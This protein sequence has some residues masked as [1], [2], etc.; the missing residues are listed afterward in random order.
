MSVLDQ[1]QSPI[2]RDVYREPA[3]VHH[4]C[5]AQYNVQQVQ[6][7]KGF[8]APPDLPSSS[9]TGA[10]VDAQ[11]VGCIV[12]HEGKI[13]LCKRAIDPC[14][15]KWTLPAGYMELKESSAGQSCPSLTLWPPWR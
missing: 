14:K 15:G 11:V 13:L 7:H 3:L 1:T 12:E 8:T 9:V 2:K 4:I 6:P 5:T 10:I